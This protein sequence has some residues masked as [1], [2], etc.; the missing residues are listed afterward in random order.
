MHNNCMHDLKEFITCEKGSEDANGFKTYS[1]CPSKENLDIIINKYGPD[2]VVECCHLLFSSIPYEI[3]I[4]RDALLFYH[5]NLKYAL[6][7]AEAVIERKKHTSV[8]ECKE[9]IKNY[10]ESRKRSPFIGLKGIDK[11]QNTFNAD[12]I[13]KATYQLIKESVANLEI[14]EKVTEKEVEDINNLV[15]EIS[16]YHLFLP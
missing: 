5:E 4:E 9:V 6:K 8:D 16:S 14:P 15:K 13:V 10:L 2:K 11:I 12:L 1:I 3:A 7:E